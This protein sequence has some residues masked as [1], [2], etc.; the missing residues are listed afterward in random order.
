VDAKDGARFAVSSKRLY[1]S[2]RGQH[3]L[4]LDPASHEELGS[5]P[6]MG[7]LET[8]EAI[9]AASRAFVDW[10]RTTAKVNSSPH[11]SL[12]FVSFRDGTQL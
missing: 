9:G 2:L 5:V 3:E 6:E 11:A 4:V 10:S 12:V 7:P 8:Q 1:F